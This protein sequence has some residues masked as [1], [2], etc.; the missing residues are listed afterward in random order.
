MIIGWCCWPAWKNVICDL[1]YLILQPAPV[2]PPKT[3]WMGV[4]SSQIPSKK[5]TFLFI[6]FFFVTAFKTIYWNLLAIAILRVG[7]LAT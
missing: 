1:L 7:L 4:S 2:F 3:V 6:Y 5:N